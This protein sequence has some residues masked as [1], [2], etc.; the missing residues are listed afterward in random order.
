VYK[1]IPNAR[2][3]AT[4]DNPVFVIVALKDFLSGVFSE[5]QEEKADA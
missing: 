4:L 3:L 2:H 1:V 5:S